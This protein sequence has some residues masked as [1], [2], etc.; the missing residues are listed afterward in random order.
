M[1]GKEEIKVRRKLSNSWSLA[2]DFSHLPWN[3]R[4]GQWSSSAVLDNTAMTIPGD[5]NQA[6]IGRSW[7]L[8]RSRLS[9]AGT[10]LERDVLSLSLLSILA[11]GTL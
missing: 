3:D 8:S 4:K 5:Q 1:Y 6:V 9:V 11:I 2:C 7:S 10:A